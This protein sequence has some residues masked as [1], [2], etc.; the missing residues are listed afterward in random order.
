LNT[1]LSGYTFKVPFFLGTKW[2]K[3]AMILTCGIALLANII[4]YK[5]FQTYKNKITSKKYTSLDVDF[6]KFQE[7]YDQIKEFERN[8]IP[9]LLAHPDDLMI[10]DAYIGNRQHVKLIANGVKELYDPPKTAE[11][12][13]SCQVVRI[14]IKLQSLVKYSKLTLSKELI[15]EEGVF[16]PRRKV[17]DIAIFV[18]FKYRGL[19]KKIIK[20]FYN[21]DLPIPDIMHER[22]VPEFNKPKLVIPDDIL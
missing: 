14:K 11:E 17:G 8:L 21:G 9:N 10:I 6:R 13:N 18:H 19:N 16:N 12:Y 22:L 2:T 3:G 1:S 7:K 4:A 20:V 15:K 5:G